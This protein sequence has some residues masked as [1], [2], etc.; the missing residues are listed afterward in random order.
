MLLLVQVF[1]YAL[2]PIAPFTWFQLNVSTL[3]VVAAFRLC[4]AL[5]QIKD[6]YHSRH[7]ARHGRWNVEEPSFTRNLAT[8]LIVVYGG[9][10]MF[11]T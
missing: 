4:I 10:A 3:D 7:V 1:R 8:T 5:R 11:C 2:S 9:E 6:V